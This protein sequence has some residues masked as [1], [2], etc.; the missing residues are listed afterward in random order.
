MGR[1]LGG[2]NKTDVE[3]ESQSMGGPRIETKEK[4]WG[5]NKET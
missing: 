4:Y 5:E 2:S 1:R 3:G